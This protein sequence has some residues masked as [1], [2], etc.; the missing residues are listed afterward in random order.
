MNLANFTEK[1][2]WIVVPFMITGIITMVLMTYNLN[3][4][5]QV[6][7]KTDIDRKET[8]D[9]IWQIATDNQKLVIENNKILNEKADENKNTEAH[10]QIMNKVIN[11]E[12]KVDKIYRYNLTR[13]IPYKESNQL[14]VKN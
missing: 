10:K 13:N 6:I 7:K 2:F 9:K 8:V 3:T 5:V 12:S 14:W 1:L 4:D 11:I